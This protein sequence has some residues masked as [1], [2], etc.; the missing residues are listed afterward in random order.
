MGRKAGNLINIVVMLFIVIGIAII[1]QR[2]VYAEQSNHN[3]IVKKLSF[4]DQTGKDVEPG[5]KL[6]AGD[7]VFFSGEWELPNDSSDKTWQ[8]GDYFEVELPKILK[9]AHGVLNLTSPNGKIIFAKGTYDESKN[10]YRFTFTE[11]IEGLVN[12][13]GGFIF[14][15]T[16]QKSKG[17][18]QIIVTVNG[19]ELIN[20]EIEVDNGTSGGVSDGTFGLKHTPVYKHA[21]SQDGYGTFDWAAEVNVV[22]EKDYA[23][24]LLI[25]EDI[26]A[27][28]HRV[29]PGSIR[30]S[31]VPFVYTNKNGTEMGR[32]Y[33]SSHD[34]TNV[35]K[36]DYKN[37]GFAAHLDGNPLGKTNQGQTIYRYYLV[38]YQTEYDGTGKPGEKIDIKNTANLKLN[39]PGE[40]LIDLSNAHF[41]FNES[42]WGYGETGQG[43]LEIMKRDE[44]T[45]EPLAGAQFEISEKNNPKK[46]YQT[47]LSDETGIAKVVN[48]D[49]QEIELDAGIYAISE[50]KA[51]KGYHQSEQQEFVRIQMGK[52][53]VLT[54]TNKAFEK[55]DIEITKKWQDDKGEQL[56]NPEKNAA[57]VIFN[58]K[59]DDKTIRQASLDAGQKSLV[60]KG[61]DK[62]DH[63]GK[64]IQYTVEETLSVSDRKKFTLEA[65][66]KVTDSGKVTFTN[67]KI[68]A[69]LGQFKIIKTS[70]LDGKAL[71]GA[72]FGLI[73][74]EKQITAVSDAEGMLVFNQLT[75][76][77]YTLR[78]LSAPKG[79]QKTD[80][81]YQVT[82]KDGQ[83]SITLA[84][85]EKLDAQ[86][87]L[88]IS[89][90]PIIKKTELQVSKK[91]QVKDKSLIQ[92][93]EMVLTVNEK[94][95][96]DYKVVLSEKNEWQAT[97]KDLPT[98]KRVTTED[99]KVVYQKLNYGVKELTTNTRLENSITGDEKVGFTVTNVEKLGQLTLEKVDST[100]IT[101]GLADAVFEISSAS[102]NSELVKT[103]TTDANGQAIVNELPFG[104]YVVR[105]VAAPTGYMLDQ[106]PKEIE[107]I[108][109]QAG[110]R[111]TNLL[112]TNTKMDQPTKPNREKG[113]LVIHK[114]DATD[115]TKYLAG[116][117][118]KLSAIDGI[119]EETVTTNQLGEIH[120]EELDLGNYQLEEIQAPDGYQRDESIRTVQITREQSE[121]DLTISNQKVKPWVPVEPSQGFG[122]LL[123]TKYNEKNQSETLSGAIFTLQSKTDAT[124]KFEL[125]TNANGIAQLDKIPVG[126]Y[127]LIE[128]KAP[129][130]YEINHTSHT[131]T[132]E[133]GQR[134]HVSVGNMPIIEIPAEPKTGNFRL[135]K[136]DANHPEI[137]LAGAIF[138]LTSI[139][140][141][142]ETYAITTNEAGIAEVTDLKFG[143][144]ELVETKAPND[145]L[146]DQGKRQIV[147]SAENNGWTIETVANG[148]MIV[149]VKPGEEV[150][151]KDKE[152]QN[153]INKD[154]KPQDSKKEQP[155]AEK[156][157]ATAVKNKVTSKKE[158][159][160]L[161]QTGETKQIFI[162]KMGLLVMTMAIIVIVLRKRK[163]LKK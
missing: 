120:F 9:G 90:Q 79:Y 34:V 91:W 122:S 60:F 97:F 126:Q 103:V 5:A 65:A 84:N 112:V 67:K 6:R 146:I 157:K 41:S 66:K 152:P 78:E 35:V 128:T 121:V 104:K 70:E 55:V 141:P 8:A 98:S 92:P 10:A 15:A 25:F 61:L 87:V 14:N 109:D 130:G 134:E 63:A 11:E 12:R 30:I 37:N 71:Q 163:S 69:K 44:E 159:K 40:D 156:E 27:E 145:Y 33:G 29:I 22:N 94:E 144:Y 99:G 143:T 138:K 50:V 73:K 24:G 102:L 20:Q 83:V 108:E 148:R 96:F 80:A 153:P 132:I 82:V 116:A 106:T 4:K 136:V 140:N 17:K 56:N 43:Q 76:G 89:N 125:V 155:K 137:V 117:V 133:K 154:E 13:K 139:E 1:P 57:N 135:L 31:E 72:E 46:R 19:K 161:P 51:P 150:V 7:R 45:G 114:V 162:V 52:K 115:A 93:V 88:E 3:D 131:I 147:I 107:V 124:V 53:A 49:G 32:G 158:T 142:T 28:H 58:L 151:P 26:P 113:K 54:V 105:E 149:D 74:G 23:K 21:M 64:L 81:I 160:T 77:K 110:N 127:E 85:E 36:I 101:Q 39:Q 18:E 123:L 86:G 59:Q 2:Q 38:S 75:D 16:V 48:A 68:P 118:F 47:S 100:D 62:F 95:N 42:A 111:E 119:F 129:A